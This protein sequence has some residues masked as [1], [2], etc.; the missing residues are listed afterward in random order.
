M[1][2][3]LNSGQVVLDSTV[4]NGTIVIRGV[5]KLTDNS[6]GATVDAT[7]LLSPDSIA[8]AVHD[9]VIEGTYTMRQLQRAFL[10][11]LA[12]LESGGD[13]SNIKFRD[14]AATKN[15]IDEPV[16]TNGKRLSVTLD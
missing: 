2:I 1:S 10:S 12:G 15:R 13:T 4:T 7:H 11:A 6:V 5:G 3:D 8:D 14:V 9:E 16:D